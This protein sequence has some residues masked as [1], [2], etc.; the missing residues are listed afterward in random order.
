MGRLYQQ[1]ALA[2]I[3]RAILDAK[4]IYAGH[5]KRI[6][7][8]PDGIQKRPY[9]YAQMSGREFLLGRGDPQAL[10]WWEWAGLQPFTERQLQA[11]MAFDP[12]TLMLRMRK[13]WG[14]AG[15]SGTDES[16]SGDRDTDG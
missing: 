15:D 12:H 13:E 8:E 2:V 14:L 10:V 4:G 11:I 3:G 16:E 5:G 7:F 9:V 1:L 6:I